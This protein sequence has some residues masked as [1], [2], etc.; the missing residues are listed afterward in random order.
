MKDNKPEFHKVLNVAQMAGT[1][2]RKLMRY[3]L[4]YDKKLFEQAAC[5]GIDTSIFYPDK[6]I[7]TREE[8]NMF[9]RMCTD[10]PV[11]MACLEWGLAHERYGI[12][13]GTTPI[14]RRS[15][16]RKIGWDVV[17]PNRKPTI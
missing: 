13:G 17:D 14:Q 5:I 9:R 4:R 2:G 11:M 8:E 1:H 15:I 16:R 10:C 3:V 6:D 12:W 7:F